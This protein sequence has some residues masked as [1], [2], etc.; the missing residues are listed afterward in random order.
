MA[1]PTLVDCKRCDDTRSRREVIAQMLEY[2]ANGH[3]YGSAGE[4]RDHAQ[5]TAEDVLPPDTP[6]HP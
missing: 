2:S 3:R 6:P 1:M 4:L 5:Q